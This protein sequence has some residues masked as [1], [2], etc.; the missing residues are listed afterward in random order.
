MVAADAWKD[1]KKIFDP[2]LVWTEINSFIKGSVGAIEKKEG[3]LSES[4]YFELG[5]KKAPMFSNSTDSRVSRKSI[6]ELFKL[7]EKIKSSGI[8]TPSTINQRAQHYT[9]YDM[10][11]LV[12]H[13]YEHIKTH[14]YT[15]DY[16]HNVFVDEVQD[17]NEASLQLFFL[18]CKN[19]KGFFMCGDTAQTIERGSSFRFCD[20]RTL[21]LNNLDMGVEILQ[22]SNSFRSTNQI[23]VLAHSVIELIENFFPVTIDKL[24]PDNGQL[25]GPI[26]LAMPTDKKDDLLLA[27]LG[28]EGSGNAIEFGAQQVIVVRDDKSK[29]KLPDA[30]KSNLVMTVLEVKGLEF[31][32]VL[33]YNFFTDSPAGAMWRVVNEYVTGKA[34][35]MG[36]Q[37]DLK[38]FPKT[39]ML[40]VLKFNPELHKLLNS[41]L[42][43]LYMVITRTKQNLWYLQDVLS[44]IYGQ[45]TLI[46][47]KMLGYSMK[48]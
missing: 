23:L 39:D 2:N 26:P 33:L 25:Q 35:T 37:E 3:F 30:L 11:D 46:I 43:Q 20:L 42:K 21:F 14:G 34:T 10:M 12:K 38:P 9:Y 40:R 16:F 18:I 24:R 7:Y 32:D 17:L 28:S 6:Y 31:D 41:E 27:F 22:L 44:T 15:G 5:A 19:P 4:E 8:T 45:A 29:E 48:S 36:V 13:L 47:F 1:F